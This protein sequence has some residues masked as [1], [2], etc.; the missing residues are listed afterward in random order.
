MT[1]VLLTNAT[2]YAGPGALEAL[3]GEGHV[4]VCHDPTFGDPTARAA[5]D[6]ARPRARAIAAL[7]PEDVHREVVDR[8]D[9]PD[10][11]VLNAVH[12]ITRT[13][14]DAID[15]W[16]LRDAFAQLVLAPIRLAQ[17][18]L[19]AFRERRRGAFV[20]VTSA[21]EFCPE[22]GFAAPTALRAAATAF[23][24]ALAKEAA[25]FGVQVNV[26]APNYLESEMYY[27]RHRFVDD[28]AGRETVA[29]AV[30][31]GRLGQQAEVGALIAFLASGKSPFTTGQVVGFTGGWP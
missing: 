26:V 21:R 8:W 30:P 22:P 19:P 3:L 18:F 20:F 13:E 27:P 31:F 1:L 7:S 28:P 16:D 29:R 6:R 4:V 15:L 17:L 10:A 23:G 11:I 2:Q 12:P 25:P 24:K 5:F 14:F 9:L